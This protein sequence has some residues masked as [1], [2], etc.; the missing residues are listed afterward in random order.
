MFVPCGGPYFF[1]FFGFLKI[2]PLEFSELV[3][4]GETWHHPR[5]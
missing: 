4:F 5:M 3:I 2:V 1:F